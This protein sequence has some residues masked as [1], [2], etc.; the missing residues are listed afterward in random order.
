MAGSAALR[1]PVCRVEMV[2]IEAAVP[3]VAIPG[4]ARCGGWWLDGLRSRRVIRGLLSDIER[5]VV[6][7]GATSS[8][9]PRKA[10]PYRQAPPPEVDRA[11]PVCAQPMPQTRLGDIGVALDACA[12]HGTWFDAA[13]L[14]AVIRFFE[15]ASVGGDRSKHTEALVRWAENAAYAARDPEPVVDRDAQHELAIEAGMRGAALLCNYLD[16]DHSNRRRRNG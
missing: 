13:E 9:P 11:C 2:E 7:D 8:A 5:A 16:A 15:L 6:A 1:C 14:L 4:C 10:A 12:T 3:G